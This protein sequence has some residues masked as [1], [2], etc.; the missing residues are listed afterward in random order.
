V[1]GGYSTLEAYVV[2]AGVQ[3][4]IGKSREFVDFLWLATASHRRD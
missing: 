2:A 4:E 3:A 1:K